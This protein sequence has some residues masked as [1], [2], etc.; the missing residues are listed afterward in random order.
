MENQPRLALRAETQKQIS[1]LK[2]YPPRMDEFNA[3][4]I[5]CDPHIIENMFDRNIRSKYSI[6]LGL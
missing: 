3:L 6:E 4:Y 2:S 1:W 5:G